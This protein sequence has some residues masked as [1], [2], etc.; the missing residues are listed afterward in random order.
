MR[1]VELAGNGRIFKKIV[2]QDGI[3]AGLSESAAPKPGIDLETVTTANEQVKS[4]TVDAVKC[5]LDMQ[6]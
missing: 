2:T 4:L 1:S 3:R 6:K 5:H